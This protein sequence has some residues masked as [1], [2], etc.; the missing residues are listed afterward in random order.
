MLLEAVAKPL[1]YRWPGGE[2]RLV[3]GQPADLPED[4]ALKLLAKAPGRVR[5]VA[6]IPSE[7]HS[8]DRWV[9]FESPLFGRCRGRLIMIDGDTAIIEDHSVLN[10]AA[11]IKRQWF[12]DGKPSG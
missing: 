3:P 8:A 6:A 11:C 9:E 4:R 7:N 5:P 2:V 12:C 10:Q 1:I